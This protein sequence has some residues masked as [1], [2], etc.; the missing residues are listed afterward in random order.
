MLVQFALGSAMILLTVINHG[1]FSAAG[2]ALLTH[3]RFRVRNP[4]THIKAAFALALF[5]LWMFLSTILAS[6]AW[7]YLY[8]WVGALTSFSESIYFSMVTMTTLGYGDIVLDKSWHLLSA[9]EGAN[10]SFLLG[11]ST[12]L[13]FYA[14]QRVYDDR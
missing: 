14:M 11:W 6:F 9:I 13:T 3:C 2:V 7:A 12:A 10:G 8:V 4:T 5:V 1:L